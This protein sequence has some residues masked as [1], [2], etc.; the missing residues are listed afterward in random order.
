MCM[1]CDIRCFG[2]DSVVDNYYGELLRV[3]LELTY[4]VNVSKVEIKHTGTI[5]L[6]KFH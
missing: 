2:A 6:R 3:N 1:N 5:Q 4:R